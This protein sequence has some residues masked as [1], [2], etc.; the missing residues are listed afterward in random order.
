MPSVLEEKTVDQQLEASKQEL[1]LLY[2][3]VK[4]RIEKCDKLSPL[5]KETF[6]QQLNETL[7]VIQSKDSNRHKLDANKQIL[8]KIIQKTERFIK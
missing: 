5:L 3:E 6:E 4:E 8:G 2:L 1:D 7:A